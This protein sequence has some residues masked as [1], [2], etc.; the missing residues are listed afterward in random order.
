MSLRLSRLH[1]VPILIGSNQDNIRKD[2]ILWVDFSRGRID[3]GTNHSTAY[4]QIVRGV[5]G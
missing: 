4:I 5:G 1:F 2:D 3:N